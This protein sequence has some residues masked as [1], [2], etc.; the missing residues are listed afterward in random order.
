[1]VFEPSVAPRDAAAFRSWYADQSR[2]SEGH[3]YDDPAVTSPNLQAYF[4]DIIES[5]PPMNGPLRASRDIDD[6]KV[7]DHSVGR[8]VI[9]SAFTSSQGASGYSLAKSLARKHR[10][11]F[12]ACSESPGELLFPESDSW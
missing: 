10:L 9:Y 8:N 7:T 6:P 12:Y 5:F 4:A 11:G 1:M 2:W 3:S